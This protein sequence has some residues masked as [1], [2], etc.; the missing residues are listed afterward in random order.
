[1]RRGEHSGRLRHATISGQLQL[2]DVLVGKLD[3][4]DDFRCTFTDKG[5]GEQIQ[6]YCWGVRAKYVL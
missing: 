3:R 1:M 4:I 6:F 5:E 2:T